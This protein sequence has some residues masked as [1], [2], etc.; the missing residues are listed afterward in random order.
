MKTKL[1]KTFAVLIASITLIGS[2][3]I[4][5]AATKKK[6]HNNARANTS[7]QQQINDLKQDQKVLERKVEVSQEAFEEKQKNSWTNKFEA[8]WKRGLYFQTSDGKYSTKFRIQLQ[9]QYSYQANS[10]TLEG[11]DNQSTF[12][13]R[14][15]KISWEGNLF[16]KNLD[17]KLQ[18]EVANTNWQDVLEEAY[19][20]YKFWDPF[21]I[22]FG[23]EKVQYNR[24]QITSTGRLEFPD[25][26]L[27]SDEFR[28][29][30]IDS[31]TLTTCSF[32]AGGSVTGAGLTCG[33]GATA[34][35]STK[36]TTRYFKYDTGAVFWGQA[37]NNK[38]EYYLG[39]MNG[40]GPNRLD[41]NNRPLITGRAVY[42][43]LGNYG[44]SESDV[45]YSDHPSLFIGASGGNKKQEV[46][47]ASI[48][49]F[50]GE[51]GFKYKGASLQGEFYLRKTNPVA[52]KNTTDKGYY[53]QAG[54]FVLPRHL[55]LAARASQVFLDGPNNNKGEYSGGINYYFLGHDLKILAN[56]AYL[57]TQTAKGTAK[58]QR[59]TVQVQAWF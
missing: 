13:I 30:T 9:P 26:S 11:K 6:K 16:S 32:A 41:L 52:A 54:Y 51:T 2:S 56:Y 4:S 23:E 57:P 53:V 45:E 29:N 39:V 7:L 33:G 14:R 58:D 36:N 44:Y 18:L 34:T 38:L 37:F 31:T 35:N 19:V 43:I 20:N 12:R 40:T 46:T 47:N 10:Q 48:T 55:E 21:R 59:G 50:G 1:C 27:A 25:P 17:Y 24:Q 28:F 15:A 3:Q 8:G 42:N 22:Q 5:E 49:Q